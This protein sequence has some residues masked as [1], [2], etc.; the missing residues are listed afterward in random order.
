[1]AQSGATVATSARIF[2]RSPCTC[3]LSILLIASPIFAATK[4]IKFGKLVDGTGRVLT[5][6]I[7]LVDNDRIT[8]VTTA[9]SSIPATLR[10]PR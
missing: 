8:T 4:A 1:M 10:A 6:A 9:A 3:W 5:N 7:V 2:P